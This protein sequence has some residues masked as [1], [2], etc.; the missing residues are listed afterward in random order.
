ML[1]TNEKNLVMLSTGGTVQ[2]AKFRAPGKIT[3]DGQ[4]FVGPGTGG[5]TYNVAIGD[6]ACGWEVDHMEP[7]VS[8]K[9]DN[10]DLN[11]AYT[12]LSCI[13]N[14]AKITSGDAKGKTGFV[15]G[16]HGG[17]EHVMLYFAQDVLESLA[18]GDCIQVKAYGQGLKLLDYPDI[19]VNNIDPSLL[20]KLGIQEVA[21]KLH[22]PVAKVVPAHIMGSGI[23]SASTHSGDYDITLFDEKA[24][25][26]YG[27]KELRLGDFVLIQDAEN[28]YGR[29]Y[30]KGAATVGVVVHSD[31]KIAGHGPGVTTIL[32]SREERI[33][34]ILDKK[35]NLADILLP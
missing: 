9:N 4:V 13:G 8:T 28:R 15:T 16:T 18:I 33:V 1:R 3:I 6:A 30:I 24:N 11:Q 25:E 10:E 29:N 32:S 21:G 17:I 26:E 12:Y 31:C 34:P 22:V 14:V 7:G 23:G 5:I 19:M 27:L 2:H 20:Q 35:A